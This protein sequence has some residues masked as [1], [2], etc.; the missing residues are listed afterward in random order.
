MHDQPIVSRIVTFL[1]GLICTAN[2]RIAIRNETSPGFE[3]R[4]ELDFPHP[5]RQDLGPTLPL[6]QWVPDH[7]LA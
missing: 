1:Q 2:V 3:S 4:L 7:S 5:C 6:I